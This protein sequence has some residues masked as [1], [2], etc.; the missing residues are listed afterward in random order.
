MRGGSPVAVSAVL[1]NDQ[2]TPFLLIPEL[3]DLF[4]VHQAVAEIDGRTPDEYMRDLDISVRRL[5]KMC[6]VPYH[7]VVFPDGSVR[8]GR[9]WEYQGEHAKGFNSHSYGF[10]F[11]GNCS[12]AM[13]TRVAMSAM[14]VQLALKA[15]E[16]GLTESDIR[17]HGEL[18]Q[19]VKDCP[20]R[21]VC[22]PLVRAM[23]AREIQRLVGRDGPTVP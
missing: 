1:M 12:A 8:Q 14:V 4:V 21:Y 5:R 7:L 19:V 13:P 15:Y 2:P 11:A 20:G 9:P 22:M 10:A 6:G 23:V 3:V 18:P 17:G 16:I